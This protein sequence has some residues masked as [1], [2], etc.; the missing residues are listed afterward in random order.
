MSEQPM[1]PFILKL[2]IIQSVALWTERRS[3]NPFDSI[4]Y[5][6]MQKRAMS[7]PMARLTVSLKVFLAVTH[8]LS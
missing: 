8:Q 6:P 4:A 7:E 5:V 2:L 3:T 1:E